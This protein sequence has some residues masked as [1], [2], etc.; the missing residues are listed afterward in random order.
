MPTRWLSVGHRNPSQNNNSNPHSRAKQKGFDFAFSDSTTSTPNSTCRTFYSARSVGPRPTTSGCPSGKRKP[1]ID[2][3]L[4]RPQT[5]DNHKAS[6]LKNKHVALNADHSLIGVAFGSPSHPPAS[7]GIPPAEHI[8]QE[9]DPSLRYCAPFTE[10][11]FQMNSKKWQKKLGTLFKARQIAI[12]RE[13]V[14]SGPTVGLPTGLVVMDKSPA[15]PNHAFAEH[16]LQPLS[17]VEPPQR[18]PPPPPKD[19]KSVDKPGRRPQQD[20]VSRPSTATDASTWSELYPRKPVPKLE[21]EIPTQPLER[22]S[23]MFRN[24]PAARRSSSLLA[25]R[26]KTLD[27]LRSFD[28]SRPNTSYGEDT[29]AKTT[30]DPLTPLMPPKLMSVA[31]PTRS[32]AASKY[33]LFPSPAPIKPTGRTHVS[34]KQNHQLKRTASS[35]AALS[36]MQNYFSFARPEPLNP[37]RM[38]SSEQIFNSPEEHTASTDRRSPWSAAHS[39]QSSVSSATTADDIFFFDI[40]S[41]RDSKGVEDG[42]FVMTRPDS[43]AVELV[44]TKSK[45]GAVSS[46]LREVETPQSDNGEQAANTTTAVHTPDDTS[47]T[48]HI[49]VAPTTTTSSTTKH[50]SVNTAYFDEAIA[51]VERLT[52]PTTV[53][54]EP[55]PPFPF[56]IPTVAIAAHTSEQSSQPASSQHLQPRSRRRSREDIT[57]LIPSPVVEVKEDLSPRSDTTITTPHPQPLVLP[58]VSAIKLVDRPIGDSPTLPHGPLTLRRP[59]PTVTAND[60]E[61][62]PPP[63]PKKD[64][65]FIPLSKYAAR[66]TVTKI[67][68][69]GII[70]TRPTRSD[71]DNTLRPPIRSPSMRVAMSKE[72]SATLPSSTSLQGLEKTVPPPS[73]SPSQAGPGHSVS[74]SVAEVAVARTVSVIRKQTATAR[75]VV[76]RKGEGVDGS[77]S[78]D[79]DNRFIVGSGLGR[80]RHKRSTSKSQSKDKIKVKV[81]KR[82]QP[83]RNSTYQKMAKEAR[84]W[85][86]LEKKAYSP[87]VVQARSGHKP[88]LSV[89]LV[90]E[91]I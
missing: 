15:S 48:R 29:V 33:S 46:R 61:D 17:Q 60:T 35:P 16:R 69:T 64:A 85:E 14:P 37:K 41:F 74:N 6:P 42:Q 70:P 47:T 13:D 9:E 50:T 23:V 4:K 67:E 52:S 25:R 75:V 54:E 18:E 72:R 91:S 24:L 51:A 55:I 80:H 45:K 76:P 62:K 68:Q 88:G 40:K 11:P 20:L 43:A 66:N 81:T 34:D 1:P 59:V 56:A 5:S 57:R 32:P 73:H 77:G 36:P 84:K 10:R 27:S 65:K 22:F 7:F 3:P 44:R 58:H 28:D 90:V 21:L 82:E 87:I 83:D 63:V 79:E 26:S 38:E 78:V 39:L 31:T 12:K 8:D 2:A 30:P 53:S 89:G 19:S 86:I 71:T 49:S